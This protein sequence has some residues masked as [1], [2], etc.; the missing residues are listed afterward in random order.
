MSERSQETILLWPA[1]APLAI[2][3]TPEDQPE[4]NIWLPPAAIATGTAVVICPGGSYQG[5][6]EHERDIP[7]IYLN[8]LGIAAFCLK[9]RLG[10]R[11][12]HPAM[13]YDVQRAIR[14]VRA[15]AAEWGV[16]ADRIGVWGFSAGGHLAST[17]ATHFDGGDITSADPIERVSCRPDFA[18]LTY[19]VITMRDPFTHDGSRGALLGDNPKPELIELM[20]NDEQVT[21]ATPPTFLVHTYEDTGVPAENSVQYYLQCRQHGVLAELH[22]YQ[23]GGHGFGL[24]LDDEY[25]ANWTDRLTDWLRYQKLL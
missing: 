14:T 5:H 20:S 4:L 11:Y 10:P 12:Q 2:G 16:E 24:A 22:L 18:I 3:N 25:I 6:A 13:M 1:G 7:A 8:S 9:Y 23:H 21:A 19:P 15:R 17:A